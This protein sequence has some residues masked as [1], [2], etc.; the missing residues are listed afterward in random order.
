MEIVFDATF[1]SLLS[2]DDL[3][4]IAICILVI[5]IIVAVI[6]GCVIS[7]FSR[8]A[9][10]IYATFVVVTIVFLECFNVCPKIGETQQYVDMYNEQKLSILTQIDETYN[11]P[12]HN[13]PDGSVSK[14]IA[15][16]ILNCTS[17]DNPQ[18]V[19]IKDVPMSYTVGNYRIDGEDIVCTFNM[20]VKDISTDS[21]G[22]TIIDPIVSED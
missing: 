11:L 4:G 12:L 20:Y 16:K 5:G 18:T 10:C 1:K 6:I 7:G 13:D 14:T 9:K 3:A 19:H 22:F 8:R 15:V 21:V 2:P 17:V